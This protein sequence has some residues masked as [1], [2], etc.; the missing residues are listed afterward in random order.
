MS[1]GLGR[2]HLEGVRCAAVLVG[3]PDRATAVAQRLRLR[4]TGLDALWVTVGRPSEE[5]EGGEGL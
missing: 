4:H 5:L 2:T 3:R 1:G